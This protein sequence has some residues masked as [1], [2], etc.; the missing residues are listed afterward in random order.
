M[1]GLIELKAGW[2]NKIGKETIKR[3]LAG[4]GNPINSSFWEISRLNLVNRIAELKGIIKLIKANGEKEKTKSTLNKLTTKSIS[5][6]PIW[7]KS[8][9]ITIPGTNPLVIKSA[10]ESNWRPK[11]DSTLSNRAKNPSNKSKNTPIKIKRK[12][13][14]KRFLN[15]K[16]AAIHPKNRFKEV[17]KFGM[18]FLI[19]LIISIKL[20]P[21]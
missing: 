4:T 11:L 16:Y 9:Y 2:L 15:D 20:F 18:F 10:I 12:A 13:A 5:L 14:S 7:I 19:I 17:K 1:K 6:K 3:A 21:I 8:L